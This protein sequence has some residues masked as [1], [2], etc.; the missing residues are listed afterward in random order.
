MADNKNILGP[1]EG[2]VY[3]P[4]NKNTP[5][6]GANLSEPNQNEL[7]DADGSSIE[8]NSTEHDNPLWPSFAADGQMD[9]ALPL[10][11]RDRNDNL[12]IKGPD[13]DQRTLGDAF[14]EYYGLQNPNHPKLNPGLKPRHFVS[15]DDMTAN[16]AI[17]STNLSSGQ[18]S[19][20][21]AAH[22][23]SMQ[24][25]PDEDGKYQMFT[26]PHAQGE[27][28]NSRQY[29]QASRNEFLGSLDP[30][31]VFRGYASAGGQEEAQQAEALLGDAAHTPGSALGMKL[32]AVLGHNR[33][34]PGNLSPF[35]QGENPGD[36]SS[37]TYRQM[38]GTAD[39]A[40]KF[41]IPS[42]ATKGSY[43]STADKDSYV[44][45]EDLST[46]GIS[47]LL[48]ATGENTVG[49]GAGDISTEL[50]G[51]GGI[52]PLDD[53]ASGRAFLPNLIDLGARLD[54]RVYEAKN[55]YMGANNSKNAKLAQQ[56]LQSIHTELDEL[57]SSNKHFNIYGAMTP[58]QLGQD[59]AGYV[60]FLGGSF[61]TANSPN[62]PFTDAIAI[63]MVVVAMLLTLLWV[64]LLKIIIAFSAIGSERGIDDSNFGPIGGEGGIGRSAVEVRKLRDNPPRI[65]E[66]FNRAIDPGGFM[67]EFFNLSKLGIRET[68]N[69]F[70]AAMEL[71]I[72]AFF[73][74]GMGILPGGAAIG[75]AFAPMQIVSSPG[76][77][78]VYCRN[79]LK[80][81][82][83]LGG[84]IT[85]LVTSETSNTGAGFNV[86]FGIMK[87]IKDSGVFQ[88]ISVIAGMGDAMIEAK[89]KAIW[90]EDNGKIKE[91][92]SRDIPISPL[93]R[94][95]GPSS[96]IGQ[97]STAAQYL[98]PAGLVHAQQMLL[99]G[100]S[101]HADLRNVS[102]ILN[103][104]NHPNPDDH[105]D[106]PIPAK[107]GSLRKPA[108]RG[109][110]DAAQVKDIEDRLEAEY[111]PFYFQDM[112]T[113]EIIS[114]HAFLQT[115]NEQYSANY[116]RGEYFGRVD[117][118]FSYKSTNRTLNLEFYV[119]AANPTDFDEMWWKINKLVTLLYPQFD[120]GRLVEAKINDK[121]MKFRQ[122]FSQIMT[123]SPLC[124]LRI[125]DLV[126]S[127]RSRFGLARLFGFGANDKD[128]TYGNV[129]KTSQD[130]LDTTETDIYD[131]YTKRDRSLRKWAQSG[132]GTLGL[133]AAVAPATTKDTNGFTTPIMVHV[134]P[135]VVRHWLL[136]NMNN[137]S[138]FGTSMSAGTGALS[139]FSDADKLNIK[140]AIASLKH[141]TAPIKG[142]LTAD[143]KAAKI[144]IPKDAGFGLLKK[145][146]TISIPRSMVQP[147]TVDVSMEGVYAVAKVKD[148]D[149]KFSDALKLKGDPTVFFNATAADS[150]SANP[151]IR[152]FSEGSP[153]RGLAGVLTS[154]NFNW[155][156][157]F[158]WN[159]GDGFGT[160]G[161]RAPNACRIT[162]D[163]QVI[164][165]IVPGL[166]S[167]G[168]NRAP[169]YGVGRPSMGLVGGDAHMNNGDFGAGKINDIAKWTG[170][171]IA[172][173]Q[174]TKKTDQL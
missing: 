161:R 95:I 57:L 128:T 133:P 41:R 134:A 146:L 125:G 38:Q 3:G 170:T 18:A 108:N 104:D 36:A 139:K 34:N 23:P 137:P 68:K 55:A 64:I 1:D 30:A 65:G 67:S 8:P 74:I 75:P 149:K 66:Y 85:Q 76:F 45:F 5:E 100:A 141:A 102:R 4:A 166:D 105:A 106:G 112:R 163:F 27:D 169:V 119:F 33:F 21:K 81:A 69:D 147:G 120:Q 99:P 150:K 37:I 70:F 143:A 10:K 79:I 162:M 138:A 174:S 46:I 131:E 61:G 113:N 155:L 152:S 140:K 52:D 173:P 6:G 172:A 171:G 39:N 154:M 157:N 148:A 129:V 86:V 89:N 127:T 84:N 88:N 91:S 26:P 83:E 97:G 42:K 15:P 14:T 109:M 22:T 151:I 32:S 9:K 31:D 80:R 16:L 71:G 25:T 12:K 54:S 115:L 24:S 49:A 51:G 98:L 53:G 78:F 132:V 63:E 19:G 130:D 43:N 73:G 93:T 165:D 156:E 72:S 90:D 122:P 111:M 142:N 82:V 94:V 116:D 40:I 160:I 145:D 35:L 59:T 144:E 121:D 164:H 60:E 168:V 28:M 92:L 118:V 124:R 29:D 77:Y 87:A 107:V 7:F 56:R 58:T 20:D 103:R 158:M 101:E 110:F 126:K 117:P 2:I 13:N 11:I 17:G 123:A 50:M 96:G 153:G 44:T 167:E 47:L 135:F 136:R 48:N 62:R 114:F 159:V